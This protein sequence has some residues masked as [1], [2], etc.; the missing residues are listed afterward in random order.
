MTTIIQDII[1]TEVCE[2]IFQ[3]GYPTTLEN[4][5]PFDFFMEADID[6]TED[7][8]SSPLCIEWD[9][10]VA[11]EYA[12]DNI[13]SIR[14]TMQSMYDDLKRFKTILPQKNQTIF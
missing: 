9:F 2:Q 5:H 3:S 13:R 1:K 14:G 4:M 6:A 11:G 7:V 10:E 8:E 12:L